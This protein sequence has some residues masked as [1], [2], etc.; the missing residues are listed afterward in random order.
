M[1]DDEFDP[2]CTEYIGG[3]NWFFEFVDGNL[4]DEGE[5][6]YDVIENAMTGLTV[7][8]KVEDDKTTCEVTVNE[9]LTCQTCSL[10][11]CFTNFSPDSIKYDCTNLENGRSSLDEC[12]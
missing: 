3:W 11:G 7:M 2:D 10:D 1:C 12:E 5:T 6:D 8:V 4:V 9:T